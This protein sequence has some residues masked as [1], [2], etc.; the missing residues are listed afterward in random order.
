M[1]FAHITEGYCFVPAIANGSQNRQGLAKILERFMLFIQLG[2]NPAQAK[3]GY[4]FAL[5]VTRCAHAHQSAIVVLQRFL[6]FPQSPI[7][8]TDGVLSEG[9]GRVR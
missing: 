5:P 3:K 8:D 9:R 1:H 7:D 2:V 6:W 4:P